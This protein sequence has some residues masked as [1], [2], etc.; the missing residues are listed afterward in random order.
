VTA[1]DLIRGDAQTLLSD[2]AKERRWEQPIVSTE[3]DAPRD[4]VVTAE[5]ER[6]FQR[7][8]RRAIVEQGG[9]RRP[10]SPGASGTSA[11]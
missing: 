4:I 11:E 9:E 2:A 1:V 8:P 7:V 6:G 10:R 5:P 3:E